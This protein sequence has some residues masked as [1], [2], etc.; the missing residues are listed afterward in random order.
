M[1]FVGA[2]LAAAARNSL[3]GKRLYFVIRQESR[4]VDTLWDCRVRGARQRKSLAAVN[5]GASSGCKTGVHFVAFCYFVGEWLEIPVNATLRRGA[6]RIALACVYTNVQYSDFQERIWPPW[7]K[8]S[9]VGGQ[10]APRGEELRRGSERRVPAERGDVGKRRDGW[11]DRRRSHGDNQPPAAPANRRSR[12]H[13]RQD[14]L[15]MIV[16]GEF[17]IAV[18]HDKPI[19]I[20]LTSDWAPVRR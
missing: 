10:S 5:F 1:G 11:C 18:G 2:T 6:L 8:G 14:F 4:V 17:H 20:T 19:V 7:R 13:G 3:A 12:G 16:S 9:G 15:S